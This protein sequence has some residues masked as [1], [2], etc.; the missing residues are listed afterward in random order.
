MFS[1]NVAQIL[2]SGVT[3]MHAAFGLIMGYILAKGYRK[4]R[5]KPAILAILVSTL[6]HGLYDLCLHETIIDTP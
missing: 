1:S 6:I 3:N 4:S 2:V 5:K